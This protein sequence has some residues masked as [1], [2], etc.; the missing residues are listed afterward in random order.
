MKKNTKKK[1]KDIRS[2]IVM[3]CVMVAM[4]STASYAWFTLTDSPT[5]TGM[6]MKATA[7]GGLQVS[8]AE[9]DGFA[10]CAILFI[11]LF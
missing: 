6:Q 8:N 5:V 11:P 2:A 1:L 7:S 9:N 3:M 10:S 4:M